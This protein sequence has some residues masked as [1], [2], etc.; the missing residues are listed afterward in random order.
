[1][2]SSRSGKR[3]ANPTNNQ[4]ILENLVATKI[5][6]ADKDLALAELTA[7]ISEENVL[8]SRYFE[9]TYKLKVRAGKVAF[10]L[11]KVGVADDN[12]KAQDVKFADLCKVLSITADKPFLGKRAMS[13]VSEDYTAYRAVSVSASAFETASARY[14]T[15]NS[16]NKPTS[17]RAIAPELRRIVNDATGKETTSNRAPKPETVAANKLAE[18]N[19]NAAWA[20]GYYGAFT[21]EDSDGNKWTATTA[22]R[23]LIRGLLNRSH[24]DMAQLRSLKKEDIE[25]VRALINGVLDDVKHNGPTANVDVDIEPTDIEEKVKSTRSKK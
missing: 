21:G 19:K 14:A 6:K 4:T 5:S 13:V 15:A 3:A 17:F 11:Y 1:M 25:F 7:I 2:C 24:V 16:N 9:S 8:G 20:Y 12:V 18:H 22:D 10:D 23:N